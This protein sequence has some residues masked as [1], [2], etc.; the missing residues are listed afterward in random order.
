MI[1]RIAFP[2]G[3]AAAIS[4]CPKRNTAFTDFMSRSAYQDIIFSDA[5]EEDATVMT[6]EEEEEQWEIEKEKCSFCKHFLKSP[7][8]AEFKGWSKCVDKA[9]EEEKDFVSVC[10]AQTEALILCTTANPEYFQS[11]SDPENE[12]ADNEEEVKNS[13][14]PINIDVSDNVARDTVRGGGGGDAV[15]QKNVS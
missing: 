12:N 3:A 13:S 10:N 15:L 4:L 1:R 11:L 14:S 7:C 8:K 2:L 9:K 5:I 6:P